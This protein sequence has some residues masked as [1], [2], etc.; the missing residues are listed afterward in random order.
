MQQQQQL[1]TQSCRKHPSHSQ[2][3]SRGPGAWRAHNQTAP[4]RPSLLAPARVQERRVRR[5]AAAKLM[6]WR[7]GRAA[8]CR[9]GTSTCV[10]LCSAAA[11]CRHP[12][13]ALKSAHLPLS[14]L[15]DVLP[16]LHLQGQNR[17]W[18]A[19]SG[20]ACRKRCT[21][22]GCGDIAQVG[23]A[24]EKGS[25]CVEAQRSHSCSPG[26]SAFSTRPCPA[27]VRSSPAGVHAIQK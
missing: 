4:A 1:G 12:A 26:L 5:Q 25:I 23:W 21:A 7:T 3:Q 11:C 13:A 9:A 20:T 17:A 14:C 16:C 6:E 27:A 15:A 18:H 24:Q 2:K 19:R 8:T 22:V 10:A